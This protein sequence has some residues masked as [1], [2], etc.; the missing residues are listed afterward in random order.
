[1]N[2]TI[3]AAPAYFEGHFPG[4]PILPAVALLALVVDAL[5]R[6]SGRSVPL[7]AIP[8]LRLR[9]PV[10]PGD[11]LS[12][13]ARRREGGRVNVEL[14]RDAT[15]VAHGELDFGQPEAPVGAAGRPAAAVRPAAV[16]V[17]ELL[18]QQ[19]PMRFVASILEE[20]PQ[21]LVCEARVPAACALVTGGS[22]P[23][24]AAIEAAA[25]AAALWEAARRW[26]ES[27]E[28]VPRL[29]YL[30]ALRDVVF[31]AER[32]AAEE[33]LVAAVR[34]DAAAPPLTHYAVE[35]RREGT[36]VLRGTIAT[37]LAG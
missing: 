21:G 11:R 19:P 29:G 32:I 14:Q 28:A 31:F 8:F 9:Q 4:R 22:A 5:A 33:P 7:R 2:A 13:A 12:L 36:S 37:Y 6:E 18:P 35:V 26:R 23:A 3:T 15:L 1:M 17:A 27:H 20:T 24:L 16:P 34:L 10:G 25:Q 30:V